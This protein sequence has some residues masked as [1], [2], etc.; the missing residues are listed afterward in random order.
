MRMALLNICVE[1]KLSM[2]TESEMEQKNCSK[3]AL[4]QPKGDLILSSKFFPAPI[5]QL[6]NAR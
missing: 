4:E 3:L 1:I 5:T 2:K 6:T